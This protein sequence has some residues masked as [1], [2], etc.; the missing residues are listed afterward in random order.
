MFTSAF[1]LVVTGIPGNKNGGED[2][3]IIITAI[4]KQDSI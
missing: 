4:Y 1:T 3:E 2:K